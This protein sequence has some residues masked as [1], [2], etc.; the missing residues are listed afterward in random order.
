MFLHI[1]LSASVLS[2]HSFQGYKAINELSLDMSNLTVEFIFR[3]YWLDFYRT[4]NGIIGTCIELE[5]DVLSQVSS[6]FHH[7]FGGGPIT[8]STAAIWVGERLE[9]PRSGFNPRASIQKEPFYNRGKHSI[10]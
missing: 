2:I 8:Q 7:R 3:G 5:L 4:L 6:P 10:T 1:P 9:I